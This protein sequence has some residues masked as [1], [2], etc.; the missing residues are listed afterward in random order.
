ME[1]P[2]TITRNDRKYT[3]IKKYPNI[4]LYEDEYGIKECFSKYDLGLIQ[5]INLSWNLI[6]NG[7]TFRRYLKE[8]KK[9]TI[10]YKEYEEGKW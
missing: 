6:D 3:F 4:F 10:T 7:K 8:H 9:D 1:I 2:K 5:S